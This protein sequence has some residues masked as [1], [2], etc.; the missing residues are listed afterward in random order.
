MTTEQTP[1]VAEQGFVVVTGA[2]TGI[3]Y[4]CALHL[5]RL[6]FRV[7]AGVRKV[8][9]GERLQRAASARLVPLTIDVTDAASIAA[10]AAEV[11]R[12]TGTSG[13][14]GLVNNAGIALTGPLEFIEVDRLRRQFEVNFFGQIA[15]TQAFLPAIRRARG[16]IVNMS[17]MA[18]RVA[19]PFYAPYTASKH[20]LE[21][22]SDSLRGELAPWGIHVALIEPGA[23]NTPIWEKGLGAA[24]EAIDALPPP[25]RQRYEGIM[26]PVLR[27][28]EG[29]GERGIPTD[30][31]SE[32]VAHALTAKRPRVRYVVGRDALVA[33]TLRRFL[34]DRLMDRLLWRQMHMPRRGSLK[35]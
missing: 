8:E 3:G 33:T 1:N 30:T 22:A 19:P 20:A 7:F 17:S 10:A 11:E 15:V 21:A 9:D 29:Q 26:G 13:L 6:G 25:A 27:D 18:G 14:A 24:H 12:A 5:D 2:S 28:V 23:I 4:A 35:D 34:P 31:V 32:A 16:R